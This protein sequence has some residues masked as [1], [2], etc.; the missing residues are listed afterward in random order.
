MDGYALTETPYEAYKNGR[1]N[2]TAVLHGFNSEESGPFIILQH[3]NRRNYEEKVRGAFKEYADEVLALYPAAT[4]SEADENW[5]MLYG[6]LFFDYP[7]YCLNRLAAAQGVPVYEYRFSKHNG[8][9]GAWHSGEEIYFYGNIP[10]GSRLFDRSDYELERTMTAYF[11]NFIKTG[12]P[13]GSGLPVWN[14]NDTSEYVMELGAV[15]GMQQ[16]KRLELFA[17]FNKMT[18]W[19]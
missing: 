14:W 9:L 2:E 10:E 5:A 18:G 17:I 11:V 6:A 1:F 12:D 8:R 15:T 3:A 7:H 19:K 16:E 13:N 4:D